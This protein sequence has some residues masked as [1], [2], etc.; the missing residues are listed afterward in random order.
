MANHQ[1]GDTAALVG[2]MM[3]LRHNTKF[4]VGDAAGVRGDC[5]SVLLRLGCLHS[6]T[7]VQSSQ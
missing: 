6:T 4:K 7:A 1:M 2:A 3:R 5:Y